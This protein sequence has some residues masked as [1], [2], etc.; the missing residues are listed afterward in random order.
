MVISLFLFINIFSISYQTVQAAFFCDDDI[1]DIYVIKGND[2][3]KIAD[4]KPGNCYTTYYYKDLAAI[5]GDLIYFGCDNAG[6]GI[7]F[8]AGCFYI[9][10]TCHCYMF[11]NVDGIQYDYS[12]SQTRIADFG[13]K[14]CM[15]NGLHALKEKEV[16]KMYYYQNYVPLDASRI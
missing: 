15:F 8:G 7:T 14:I 6:K 9:Y 10:D 4:K 2:K 16:Q 3:K 5:P 11:E 1:Q 13:S 12:S